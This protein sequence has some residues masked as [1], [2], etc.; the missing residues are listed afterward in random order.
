MEDFVMISKQ[1]L[2]KMIDHSLLKR[3]VTKE[4]TIKGIELG[5]KYDV[6]SVTI[7]PCWVKLAAE[8]CKG[9]DVLVDPVIC[10]PF[11]YDTT[12]TKVFAT[13]QA[14]EDGAGEID[15][16]MNLG[17]F[18]SGEY[19][20][21]QHDMKAVVDAAQ[22]APVK[23]IFETAFFLTDDAA[24]TKVCQMAEAAGVSF[25]KTST[26]FAPAGYTF[27]QL[28]VM[29][30]AVSDKVEVKAAQGVRSL[31]DAIAVRELGVT[32]FGATRTA[33][34]MEQWEARFG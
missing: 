17:M 30:D 14:I 21:V 32:R 29:R 11:G 19:D 28:K 27:H 1:E 15:M 24:L 18:L 7:K 4:D 5:L 25:V 13:R 10:F 20:Y 33:A 23:V 9:T 16:V 8:M 31:E 34:I 2:A 22:G 26:G 6:A 3:V 12:E